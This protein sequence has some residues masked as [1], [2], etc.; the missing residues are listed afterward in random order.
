MF[1]CIL[2]HNNS[3]LDLFHERLYVSIF[4]MNR[5]FPVIFSFIPPA[6][7]V[8]AVH[9]Q[10]NNKQAHTNHYHI[11]HRPRIEKKRLT[12]ELVSKC[13]CVFYSVFR[14]RIPPFNGN[15]IFVSH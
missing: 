3:D 2:I 13:I 7:A 8:Q 1:Y 6:T 14:I 12:I 5:K 11:Y 15:V 9:Y 4:I 10:D